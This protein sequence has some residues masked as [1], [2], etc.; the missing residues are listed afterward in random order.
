MEVY[1]PDM[2]ICFFN[3]CKSFF[4]LIFFL[5]NFADFPSD[6]AILRPRERRIMGNRRSFYKYICTYCRKFG[7]GICDHHFLMDINIIFWKNCNHFTFNGSRTNVV[8][9][10]K[11][12]KWRTTHQILTM[13]IY[14]L[15]TLSVFQQYSYFYV[16]QRGQFC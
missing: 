16:Q 11:L 7:L 8:S 15:V 14:S 13:V 5:S 12:G 4:F 10:E 1:V 2:S 3:C 9:M 6:F